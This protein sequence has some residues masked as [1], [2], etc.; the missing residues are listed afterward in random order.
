MH[1]L[2]KE[3]QMSEHLVELRKVITFINKFIFHTS[4]I[5]QIKSRRL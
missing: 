3:N 1:K 5:D 2:N 4:L